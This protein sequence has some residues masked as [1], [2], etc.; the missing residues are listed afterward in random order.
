VT[1]GYAFTKAHQ[2]IIQT[3]AIVLFGDFDHPDS[4]GNWLGLRAGVYGIFAHEQK[5]LIIG[6]ALK[7]LRKPGC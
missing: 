4:R 3:L 1:F 7:G 5:R 2:K 6:E